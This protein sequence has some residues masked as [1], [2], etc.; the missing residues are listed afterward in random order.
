M[1][2]RENRPYDSIML[3]DRDK[4]Y[5]LWTKD[6]FVHCSY[7]QIASFFCNHPVAVKIKENDL[8]IYG[9]SELWEYIEKYTKLLE[10]NSI[11]IYDVT[12]IEKVLVRIPKSNKLYNWCI[13]HLFQYHLRETIAESEAL[14]EKLKLGKETS[15]DDFLIDGVKTGKFEWN[16]MSNEQDLKNAGLL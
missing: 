3:G 16:G 11:D 2:I 6:E 9:G 10:S 12:S 15:F 7:M 4:R 13:K 8:D 1:E 5:V 14:I